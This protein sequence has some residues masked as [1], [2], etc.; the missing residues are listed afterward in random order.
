[1]EFRQLTYFLA[2]AQTQH[3]RKAS[4]I[5][6]VAQPA[7]SH[8]I[9][10]LE[11]ELGVALFKRVKQRVVLTPTGQEF[12]AYARGALELLQQVLIVEYLFLFEA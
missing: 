10:S 12:A 8:Q 4:E 5:C 1:M 7:L 9:A 2:A 3:F 6:L 11:A